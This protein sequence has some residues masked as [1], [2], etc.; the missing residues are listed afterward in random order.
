[1]DF[2]VTL[3]ISGIC[4]SS[5]S[6]F[7]P[8]TFYY[9]DLKMNWTDAQNYCREKYTD[10]AT[11]ASMD[12]IGMLAPAF[13]YSWAWIGLIDDRKSWKKIMSN[14]TNSWRSS[15]T[16]ETSKTG[17]QNW[18]SNEPHGYEYCVLMGNDGTWYDELCET[19]KPFI[20]YNVTKGNNEE[21][22]TYL[23]IS[24]EKTWSAARDYCREHHTDMPMIESEEENNE[25]FSVKAPNVVSW[26]GMYRVP[27]TWSDKT[28]SS[29][30]NWR[31]GSPNHYLGTQ[32]CTSE[33][34]L[35]VWD[36][37]ACSVKYPFIC[38]QAAK[39]KTMVMMKFETDA[40]ITDP[41]TNTQ[42]LQQLRAL[43]TSQGWTDFELRWKIRPKK[44]EAEKL[45]AF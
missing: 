6:H 15:S 39:L 30:T 19:L 22:K 14:E 41:A 31:S 32:D 5:C 13:P 1:M 43:L 33:S 20:C 17:Y 18:A 25:I 23:F 34:H 27:W 12:D 29:F 44:V 26:I 42:I 16:G 9:F 10:L 37:D 35:H 38:H 4:L 3:L 21:D 36:D 24:T 45:T 2:Y 11:I 28:Q 40:D 8:R 7:P